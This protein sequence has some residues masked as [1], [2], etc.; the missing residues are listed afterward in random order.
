M[1]RLE[2]HIVNGSLSAVISALPAREAALEAGVV[3]A[4]ECQKCQA[5]EP[6]TCLTCNTPVIKD[7][8]SILVV[9]AGAQPSGSM[10]R[11]DS[12]LEGK[13]E[14]E[15]CLSLTQRAE[16]VFEQELVDT[17]RVPPML[18]SVLF[19]AFPRVLF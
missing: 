18:P 14:K 19:L 9:P 5:I 16:E 6:A 7:F 17:V 3:L 1:R 11:E 10:R 2:D 13:Q 4:D 8:I 12:G 15:P